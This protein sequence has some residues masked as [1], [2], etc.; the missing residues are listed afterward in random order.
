MFYAFNRLQRR[1]KVRS[2]SFAG[3]ISQCRCCCCCCFFY[4]ILKQECSCFTR[5]KADY[6]GTCAPVSE[7]RNSHTQKHTRARHFAQHITHKCRLAQTSIQA[8]TITC[9][10]I[11]VTNTLVYA[12][13]RTSDKTLHCIN[14]SYTTLET[15]SANE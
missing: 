8:S 2:V 7:T 6:T 15:Y 13:M 14:N 11:C 4:E 5:M 12:C 10:C 1:S 9:V 3:I